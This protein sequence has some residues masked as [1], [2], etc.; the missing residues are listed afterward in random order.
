MGCVTDDPGLT[1]EGPSRPGTLERA[2]LEV[3]WSRDAP[4]SARE[5]QADCAER[6]LAYATVRTV[7]ERLVR[8]G[9]VTRTRDGRSWSYQ[10]AGRRE[11]FVAELMMQALQLTTDRDAALAYFARS[12]TPD[13]A[14]TLR[15]ALDD[16]GSSSGGRRSQG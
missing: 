15:D 2:F 12:V 13:E 11:E 10:A 9:L 1:R 14:D 8:K 5:V 16:S 7:L 6:K 3:L 4:T